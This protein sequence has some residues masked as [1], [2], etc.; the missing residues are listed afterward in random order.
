MQVHAIFGAIK[1][2]PQHNCHQDTD[3][4]HVVQAQNAAINKLDKT[5]DRCTGP[6]GRHHQ[7]D[8][9]EQITGGQRGDHSRDVQVQVDAGT[10]QTAERTNRDGGDQAH[11]NIA[12]HGSAGYISRQCQYIF[13]RQ[14]DG[15]VTAGD[16]DHLSQ[17][18]Q[19]RKSA[20]LGSGD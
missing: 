12:A 8:R 2:E 20:Q 7:D 3:N 5:A 10:D 18:Q 13:L 11:D 1:Q 16:N 6:F 14:I 15:T 4:G 19:Q 9:V 17:S